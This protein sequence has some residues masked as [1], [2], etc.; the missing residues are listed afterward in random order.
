MR[1]NKKK[2]IFEVGVFL[3][4]FLPFLVSSL[5]FYLTSKS[6]FEKEVS[7]VG[8]KVFSLVRDENKIDVVKSQYQDSPIF[9]LYLF[10]KEESIPFFDSSNEYKVNY[11]NYELFSQI[12][13]PYYKKEDDGELFYRT[14][15]SAPN[16]TYI[17]FGKRVDFIIPFSL[18]FTSIGSSLLFALDSYFVYVYLKRK[19]NEFNLL[20]VQVRKL[21]KLADEEPLLTYE[22]STEFY[23]KSLRDA[24]RQVD[25]LLSKAKQEA[26]E[27]QFVLDSFSQGL[28]VLNNKNEIISLNKKAIG[29]FSISSFYK[30]RDIRLLDI[31]PKTVKE[32]T[33]VNKTRIKSTFFEQ[34]GPRIYKIEVAPLSFE[35][36]SKD[37]SYPSV[38]SILVDVT[39]E[40]NADKMKKDFVANA[41]HELK[42][43][44]TSILGYSQLISEGLIEDK[45]GVIETSNKIEKE[46]KRMSKIV[47]NLLRLSSIENG[48]LRTI[49]RIN[50]E[51][52]IKDLVDS[53]SIQ[54]KQKGIG[55]NI[56]IPPSM[57][58]KMNEMDFQDLF[59]NLIE[60]A[61][62]YNKEHGRILIKANESENLIYIEDSGIGIASEDL[63]RIFE[64]FYRVDKARSRKD[65]GTGLG[66][67]IAKYVASYYGF[68]LDVASI[69]NEGSKF[70]IYLKPNKNNKEKAD[71]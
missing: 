65:G 29:I 39:E 48:Q 70:T 21:R 49:I 50:L 22:D 35:K 66:L 9:R 41:S 26:K 71:K 54:I 28:V 46:A 27:N 3:L 45:E 56:D 51:K 53:L 18:Y 30:D 23:V 57:E 25:Y 42:S 13:N 47:F 43:P 5:T 16:D 40:Y 55:V 58:I 1:N 63:S 68:E 38:A 59:L 60:N 61:V 7:F 12:D 34:I 24:R 15:F 44:I 10:N 52:G 6:R 37:E 20:Q 62:K 11:S 2:H 69:L 31:A 19:R 32:M 36:V 64:R 8:E 4:S 17:V 14:Y 67:S 33:T